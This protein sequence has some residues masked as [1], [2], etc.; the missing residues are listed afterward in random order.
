MSATDSTSRARSTWRET[1]T[2][3]KT[4]FLCQRTVSSS[5]PVARAMSRD[6]PALGEL[7]HS[8]ETLV[9]R[10]VVAKILALPI[11]TP[12]AAIAEIRK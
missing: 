2:L 12:L 10:V 1:P 8:R 4:C 3:L 5:R 9:H 7:P 6:G 11:L